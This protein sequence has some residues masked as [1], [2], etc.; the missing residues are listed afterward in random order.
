MNLFV[1]REKHEEGEKIFLYDYHIFLSTSSSFAFVHSLLIKPKNESKVK[2]PIC[3]MTI[4][5]LP[6][7]S[8]ILRYFCICPFQISLT[9][10]PFFLRPFC[11]SLFGFC[12]FT[13]KPLRHQ[14]IFR[15]F[16]FYVFRFHHSILLIKST[17]SDFCPLH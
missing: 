12:F 3:N 16:C 11:V 6:F 4:S 1:T 7:F 13:K 8:S 17:E 10:T 5:I 15:L 2:W 14:K 9:Q